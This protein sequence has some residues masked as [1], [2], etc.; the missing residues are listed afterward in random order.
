MEFAET[1][2]ILA[3]QTQSRMFL[4]QWITAYRVL[5]SDDGTHW[6]TY[7]TEGGE[8][9]VSVDKYQYGYYAMCM[10]VLRY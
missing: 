4:E 9:R 1:R 7:A 8:H 6:Q 5:Y 10:L 3:V 2:T